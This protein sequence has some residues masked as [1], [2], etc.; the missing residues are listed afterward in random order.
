[1]INIDD[2]LVATAAIVYVALKKKKKR[3][4]GQN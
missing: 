1:M 2:E 4:Y 3:K